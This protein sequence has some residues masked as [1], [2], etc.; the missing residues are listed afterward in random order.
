MGLIN[1]LKKGL[2]KTRKSLVEET[3]KLARGRK[4]DESLL[5][6]FEELLIMADI[7]PQAAESITG[8]LREKVKQ[9]KIRNER[10]LKKAFKEE[11]R[12]ILKE[13]HKVMCAGEN[14]YVILTI[15]VNGVGKTTTIGKLARHFTDHGF[16]VTLAAADTFRA[17]AI[18]QLEIWADRAGAQIVKHRSGSDPAAVAFDAVASARSKN[19]DIVI[20]DTA[21][22][23][24]TKSNL[25]EELKKIKRV[26]SKEKPSA[27]HEVLLV[28][29]ATSG[30]NAINQAK[31]FNDAVGVTGIALTKLDGSAKGGIVLA[32]NK[33]LDIPVKLIGVGEA[34]EDL[35]DFNPEEFVEALFE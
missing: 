32:I 21:G 2:F 4:V 3:E 6:E 25:M 24:H 5:E 27:P 23:L 35:Q 15:G 14:P 1:K 10:D 31:I 17:A 11:V 28:V 30:Q 8:A 18:E 19:I 7:G 16:T 33:E 22:R 13:G 9:D 12:K 20:I 29:D 26:I 34:V